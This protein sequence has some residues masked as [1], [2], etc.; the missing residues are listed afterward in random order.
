VEFKLSLGDRVESESVAVWR[1]QPTLESC[2]KWKPQTSLTV[3]M[4]F[5]NLELLH[6]SMALK[7]ITQ[8][9]QKEAAVVLLQ[10]VFI[11][12]GTTISVM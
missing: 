12:E 7:Y 3:N 4:I 10:E 1:W 11:R 5:W 9:L 8:T 6:L 2:Q